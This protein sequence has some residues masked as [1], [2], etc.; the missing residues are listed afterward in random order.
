MSFT[1]TARSPFSLRSTVMSHG[2][3]QLA[4]YRFDEQTGLL[5]YVDRLGSGRVLE[6]LIR[7]APGGVRVEAG[8]G[9]SRPERAEVKQRIGWMLGLD[10][11]FSEFYAEARREPKLSRA[12]TK[13]Q[14]RLLRCPTLFEDVIKTI[15]TTN[16]LWG[17]T[18]RM[19][20]NLVAQYG[21]AMPGDGARKTFPGPERLART[22]EA[23][24]RR[25]TRL[26]YRAPYVLGLARSIASGSLDL[27]A[28]KLDQLPTS[29]LRKQLLAIKGVGNYA[30]ANLLVILGRYDYLPVDSWALKMVSH[31]W[32]DGRPVT[33]AEVEAAFASW[34]KWK[35]LAYFLWDWSE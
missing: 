14:G 9:L 8:G 11:D 20:A 29:D 21:D 34:G 18:K 5:T 13:A 23:R 35:G 28:L 16:T 25:E 27:E 10:M 19:T 15:L 12:E 32:H 22:T 3:L 31:E 17:A 1:L 30:A 4:P 7:E 2:W 26:G 33:A 24:L 6:Y